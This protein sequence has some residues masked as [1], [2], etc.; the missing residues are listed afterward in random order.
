MNYLLAIAI[1]QY[2][3]LT[4]LYNPVRDAR[5]FIELMIERYRFDEGHVVTIFDEEATEPRIFAAFRQLVERITPDDNLI[6]YYS[7]H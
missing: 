4:K 1:D 6:V 3:H 2:H 7:G 5:T